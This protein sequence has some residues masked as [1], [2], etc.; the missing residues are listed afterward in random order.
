MEARGPA[1]GRGHRLRRGRAAALHLRRPGLARRHDADGRCAATPA[2][3]RP[4]RRSRS[5]GSR[6]PRA[7]SRPPASCG[8]SPGSRPRSPGA[9]RSSVDLRHP[10]AEALA[11][12][13]DGGA[14]RLRARRPSAAAASSPRR[15]VWRIEPIAFDAGLVVAARGAPARES[16]ASRPSLASGALHDAAEVARVLPAAMLFAPS[17]GGISHA[18]EEDTAEAD[19]RGRDR[20]LRRAGG[21]GRSRAAR[22]CASPERRLS[23][24]S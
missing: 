1:R 21:R 6:R 20:G 18:P 15:R 16:P 5:S 9:R 19:L 7:A 14:R 24:H 2:S 17:S 22:T 10:E 4:R 3:R 11:R 23:R 12:M 13:L 8:S